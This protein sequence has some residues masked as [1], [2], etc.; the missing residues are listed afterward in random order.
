MSLLRNILLFISCLIIFSGKGEAAYNPPNTGTG[1]YTPPDTTGQWKQLSGALIKSGSNILNA[2]SATFT[3]GD[4]GSNHL[5]TIYGAGVNGAALNTRISSYIDTNN[6]TITTNASSTTS[7]AISNA[8]LAGHSAT[9]SGA[10]SYAAG[11]TVTLTGGSSTAPAVLNVFDTLL[12]SASVNAAGSG[13]TNGACILTGT[14]GTGPQLFQINATISG[15]V[16]SA[17]GT[18][19]TGG[20]YTTNPTSLAAEPVTSNCSLTGATLTLNMGVDAVTVNQGGLYTSTPSNPVSQGSTSG[21]GTGATF[22]INFQTSGGFEYGIDDTAALQAAINATPSYNTFFAPIGL[23]RISSCLNFPNPITFKGAGIFPITAI[24]DT[25]STAPYLG[26]TVI[27]QTTA[28]TDVICSPITK[29]VLNLE[30]FG[31]RFAD[32]IR[33]INTGNGINLAP[34]VLVGGKPDIGILHSEWRNLVGF[35]G[36]GN[37]YAYNALNSLLVSLYDIQS[38][39]GGGINWQTNSTNINAGNAVFL[40]VYIDF[41]QKGTANGITFQGNNTGT[42]GTENLNVMVRPQVNLEDYHTNGFPE[43]TPP[44]AAQ[45]SFN[46]LTPGH[47]GNISIIS[48]DFEPSTAP[49]SRNTS[50]G[51]TTEDGFFGNLLTG[52]YRIFAGFGTGG[53]RSITN[54][55]VF[56]GTGSHVPTLTAQA[57]LGGTPPA[58]VTTAKGDFGVSLTFGT[59]TSAGSGNLIR[60]QYGAFRGNATTVTCTPQNATTQPLGIYPSKDS[61]GY[62]IASVNAPS[63]SQANTVYA[64]DCE[65]RIDF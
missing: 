26:G 61:S 4:A 18:V 7:A 15:N 11:D 5:I 51:F 19:I 25:D 55:G 60:V 65:M 57:A 52:A 35:G 23:Y 56:S 27:L 48:P 43:T 49:V 29:G 20:Q 47:S 13:G 8:Y 32:K 40:G 17:L 54:E 28:A 14:T 1:V 53:S 58:F 46:D 50:N 34:T 59:G 37:H 63:S 39:G 16:I 9:Q 62:Y 64:V 21:A 38:Y 30:D 10:G 6:I 45:F 33:F 2:P 36:D 12:A 24:T 31:W 22:N 41:I 3:P 44:D 42:T